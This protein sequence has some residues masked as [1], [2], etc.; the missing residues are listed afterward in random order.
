MKFQ[1]RQSSA[2]T[3]NIANHAVAS[4][5]GCGDCGAFAIA[6]QVLFAAE[7]GPFTLN[8]DNTADATSVSC[9]K[10]STLAAAYQIIYVTDSPQRLTLQ[11]LT[12]QQIRG[13]AQIGANCS[14]CNTPARP[15]PGQSSADALANQAV[16][17]LQDGPSPT[18][19]FSPALTA[20][21]TRPN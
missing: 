18:R 12:L 2:A 14:P 8:A 17:I 15:G 9:A 19:V 4:T 11:R 5:T 3:I 7:H 13:L 20:R 10:C 21:I 1:L 16:S 6:F